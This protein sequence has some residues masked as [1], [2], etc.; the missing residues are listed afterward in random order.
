MTDIMPY[1]LV[2]GTYGAC[3]SIDNSKRINV[4]A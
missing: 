2:P 1:S 4:N 3:E